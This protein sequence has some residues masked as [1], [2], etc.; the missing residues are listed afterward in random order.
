MTA[1]LGGTNIYNPLKEMIYNRNYGISNDTT[2]N[3]FL[4][5]DGLDDADPIIKLVKG[6]NK[7]ETRIY[8]LGIGED[9]SYYLVKRVAEEGNGKFHVV[10]EDGDIN[11][12]VIDLLEDSLTPYLK[13]F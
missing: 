9:C 2:L 12:K 3:V 6:K 5:T 7:A 1:N 11:E 8:T 13:D 4:L 10:R